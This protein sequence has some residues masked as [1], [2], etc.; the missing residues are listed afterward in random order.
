MK[1]FEAGSCRSVAL[2]DRFEEFHREN[3]A[4]YAE[5]VRLARRWTSGGRDRVGVALLME[6]ARW[7]LALR[8]RGGDFKINNNFKPLYARLIMAQE[9]DLAGIFETRECRE[10]RAA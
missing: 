1:D 5:L 2:V 6:V 7:N 9:P 10:A 4:V 3:P 8:T